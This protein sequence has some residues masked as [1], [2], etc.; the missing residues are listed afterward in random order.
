MKA[1]SE[2]EVVQTVTVKGGFLKDFIDYAS[3]LTNAP[4]VLHLC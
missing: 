3:P 1:L 4:N 2:L